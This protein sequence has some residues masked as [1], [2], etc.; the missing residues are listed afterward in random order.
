MLD[1]EGQI[2]LVFPG[3]QQEIP[4]TVNKTLITVGSVHCVPDHLSDFGYTW[5][6][7]FALGLKRAWFSG[8]PLE[9]ISG[10]LHSVQAGLENLKDGKTSALEHVYRSDE[11]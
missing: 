1:P 2:S 10:G 8:H 3:Q 7:L 9:V 6:R 4:E 5:F 11:T